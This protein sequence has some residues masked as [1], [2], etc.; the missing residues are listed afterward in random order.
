MIVKPLM[1]GISMGVTT[2]TIA[3]KVARKMSS[4]K[5]N[6]KYQA[7]KTLKSIGDFMDDISDM[8]K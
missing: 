6:L 4:K 5:K 2:G 8:M 1:T 7:R 3:F